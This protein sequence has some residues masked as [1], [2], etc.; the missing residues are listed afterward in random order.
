MKLDYESFYNSIKT[1]VKIIK[2]EVNYSKRRR[3]INW[4]N[5]NKSFVIQ[6]ITFALAIYVA[7]NITQKQV[8]ISNQS[9]DISKNN[10]EISQNNIENSKYN[11]DLF[12]FYEEK[13]SEEYPYSKI[14]EDGS[15]KNIPS[16]TFDIKVKMGILK[17]VTVISLDKGDNDKKEIY[18][19]ATVGV[20]E[21]EKVDYGM[22]DL[23]ININP[24]SN[25]NY[26]FS[27]DTQITY[28]NFFVLLEDAKGNK[29]LD[30]IVNFIDF[31]RETVTPYYYT[32][33]DILKEEA[34]HL[35]NKELKEQFAE[36]DFIRESLIAKGLF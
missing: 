22:S 5:Q 10:L 4:I 25:S 29:Y 34:N 13:S 21:L 1:E 14:T 17:H 12:Y 24:G 33:S 7:F 36:F 9:L 2:Y 23:S 19:V 35:K 15:I 32:E 6:A 8:E 11:Q 27:D 30:M 26:K 3:R 16:N 28:D 20:K 31:E 18:E